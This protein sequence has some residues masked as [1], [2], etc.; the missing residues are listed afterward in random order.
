MCGIAGILSTTGV[1]REFASL[2]AMHASLS[3]R[4][5]DDAGTWSAP[6][7]AA[8]FA[9]RRLAVIDLTAGGRQPMSVDEGR[10][11]ITYNGEVYNYRELRGELQAAG[12]TFRTD[13]DTEVI[14]RGYEAWGPACVER[15]RGM[16]AFA[17]WDETRRAGFLARDRF[18]IKPMYYC[19]TPGRLVFA[20]E[21]RA[22]LA[23]G[24]TPC[25][26]DAE[27][28]Y[29][30]L[31]FGS[32]RE[33]GTLL[34][35][36]RSLEPGHW[37]EW[38]E[39]SLEIRRYWSLAFSAV[40][41]DA[42]AAA[43][44]TRAA[45]LD[46]VQH[47]FV[48]DVPVGVFLSGGVDSTAL[49]AL[50]RAAGR[51]DLATFSISFPGHDGDEGPAARRTAGHFRTRHEEWRM[52][53]AEGR[54]LFERFTGAIDQPSI[55]GFNTYAISSLA[56]RHGLKVVLSGVGGDELFAGYKSFRQVPRMARWHR[57]LRAL[58]RAS[59]A[60]ARTLQRSRRARW[61]RLGEMVDGPPGLGAAYSAM[62]GIFT[63]R[64]ARR[65]AAHYTGGK[66]ADAGDAPLASDAGDRDERDAVSRL[67]LTQYLRNQLLRDS[68][69]AS[70]AWGLELRVPLLDARLVEV[71]AGIPA[72]L[73]LRTG[74]R[75][76]LEA[77]PEV[78]QWVAGQPKRGFQLPFESWLA[79]EWAGTFA[80]I[81]AS[82]PVPL[83]TWYRKWCLFMLERWM[84]RMR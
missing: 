63:R 83:E 7:R 74:K 38:R 34:A 8:A 82:S 24:L 26:L 76:L 79:A 18:G 16:F 54:D 27:G 61:R 10:L 1:E 43:A 75:L 29:G 73:R 70:M 5:P 41:A 32:V 12:A 21:V 36:V 6:S 78:P 37:A 39:G 53:G 84:E 71:L 4:G 56:R 47:H 13:S 49:V 22:M 42:S 67:E 35:G 77:V 20:S 46:S 9:H 80:R 30:Y 14:L 15:L 55:D 60:V 57:R 25:E 81:E 50:A 40:A 51:A 17:I 66:C 62:R 69:V 19:A 3:H 2:E 11:T 68:D 64:E 28:V 59:S 33:P 23:S 65:L 45:L 48:S 31:R 44:A 58:G 72:D 52:T